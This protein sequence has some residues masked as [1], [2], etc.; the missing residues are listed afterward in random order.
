M[1]QSFQLLAHLQRNRQ[2]NANGLLPVEYQRAKADGI[3]TIINRLAG[4][5]Q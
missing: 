4:T 2:A 3:P 5:Q 1:E